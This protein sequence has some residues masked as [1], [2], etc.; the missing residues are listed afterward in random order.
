MVEEIEF[1]LSLEKKEYLLGEPIVAYLEIRNSGTQ[2]TSV[3]DQLDPKFGIVKFYIKKEQEETV[4]KPYV[5]VDSMPRPVLLNPDKSIS[6]TAT[7]VYGSHGLVFNS[8]GQYKIK[9]TYNG[10]VDKPN[11]E[12]QSNVVEVNIRAPQ[13]EQEEDQ[14]NLIMEEPEA[15][16][17][18][19][20]GGGYQFK[21]GIK[22]LTE[23]ASKYPESD[24]AGYANVALGMNY[25]K[26]FKDFQR[27]EVIKADKEKSL[28]YLK[29]AT[30]KNVDGIFAKK[31]Y[32]ALADIYDKS[33]LMDAEKDTLKEYIEKFS[34]DAK[35]AKSVDKAKSILE[36]LG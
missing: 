28:S 27:G 7:L 34:G 2:A 4:F 16:L 10:L 1:K 19:Q 33:N 5:V 22:R 30:E 25:S 14:T 24:L 11:E 21:N 26:D 6:G 9:A 17:F 15:A 20:L 32:F 35:L 31:A 3:I 36:E 18:I 13:N 8:V 12:I 29:N 23:L